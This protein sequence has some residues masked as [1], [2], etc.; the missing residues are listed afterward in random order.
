MNTSLHASL[1]KLADARSQPVQDGYIAERHP[2]MPELVLVWA[3]CSCCWVATAGESFVT[4]CGDRNRPCVF[5]WDEAMQ[6]LEFLQLAEK[7]SADRAEQSLELLEAEA[8]DMIPEGG[9]VSG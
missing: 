1:A 9:P 7:N 2:S 3:P 4:S 5:N 8:S 6:A